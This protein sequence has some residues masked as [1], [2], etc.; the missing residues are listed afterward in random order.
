MALCPS[1]DAKMQKISVIDYR[2]HV[3]KLQWKLTE[4]KD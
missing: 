1:C 3:C 4:W 2:C